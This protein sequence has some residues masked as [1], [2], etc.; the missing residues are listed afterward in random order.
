VHDKAEVL[1][2]LLDSV[3]G[4]VDALRT[5]EAGQNVAHSAAFYGAHGCLKWLHSV[6][7]ASKR[8]FTFKS[9]SFNPVRK[10]ETNIDD[11]T[12]SPRHSNSHDH[13]NHNH[14]K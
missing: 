8:M 7:T 9:Q 13:N 1:V 6:S 4:G 10:F 12:A 5:D 11:S 2:W 3:G 14:S